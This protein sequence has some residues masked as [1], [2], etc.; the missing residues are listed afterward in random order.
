MAS[1]MDVAKASGVSVTTA[2]FVLNGHAEDMRI[3]PQTAQR[4]LNAVRELGYV[5]NVAARKL[6]SPADRSSVVPDIALM[7]APYMH[8][9]FLGSFITYAQLFVEKKLVPKMHITI[10]PF[11]TGLVSGMTQELLSRYYNGA[12][13]SPAV[14]EELEYVSSLNLRIP[15][16][17]LH[18]ETDRLPNVI[19]DN[20]SAGQSAAEVF[21]EKG[22]KSAA[23][24]Y[25]AKLGETSMPDQRYAGFRET[26]L[27]KNMGFAGAPIPLQVMRTTPQRAQFGRQLAADYLSTK[28]LPE[29]IFIQDEVIASGFTV[30]LLTAGV[31]IPEDIEIITY[32]SEDT[33]CSFFPAITTVDYPADSLTL[34][35][36]KLLSDQIRDPYAAPKQVAV[37]PGITFRDSCPRP[38]HWPKG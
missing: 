9:S 31:R 14:D 34:E 18:V 6:T 28:S 12:V 25:R 1:L 4:V 7:W 35:T 20:Y 38:E 13:F 17:V 10:A 32:G 19:V 27:N 16:I 37:K 15:V 26:C 3:A 36:L 11:A 24:L 22:H 23:M 8:P 33:A 2:S 30:E 5:P 29:A 21:S